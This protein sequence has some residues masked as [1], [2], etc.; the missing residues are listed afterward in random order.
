MEPSIY[1]KAIYNFVSDQSG[2][3][4]VSAGAGSGKTTTIVEC[5]N[6]IVAGPN[7]GLRVAFVAFNRNIAEELKRRLPPQVVACTLNSMGFKALC[8]VQRNWKLDGRKNVI[9]TRENMTSEAQKVYGEGVRKLIGLAKAHGILPAGMGGAALTLDTEQNW[10]DL[11]TKYDIEFEAGAEP[12]KGIEM[13]REALKV[14][15]HMA[16]ERKIVDFDDQLYLPIIWN[17]PFAQYD[18]IFADESQDI[19]AIQRAMLKKSLRPGGRLIAVGDRSQAIYGFRGADT[20]SMDNIKKE[21]AAQELPL[22]I[23]YRCAKA[24]CAEASRH[25]TIEAAESAEVGTVDDWKSA[26]AN[27]EG[28]ES[29]SAVL[30]RNNAPLVGLAFALMAQGKPVKMLGRDFGEGLIRMI[31]KTKAKSMDQ[32]ESG[33][34]KIESDQIPYLMAKGKEDAAGRLGDQIE[35]LRM[36]I[37]NLPKEDRSIEGL[38]RYITNLFNDDG[39]LITLSSVHKSKGLEWDHVYI[40][41]AHLMPSRYARQDWQKQQE[42]NIQYVALTRARKHLT[43][44]KSEEVR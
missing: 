24:I 42:T 15:I 37:S 14:S 27:G 1:Q 39:G 44:V 43:Y 36:F 35:S 17:A 32:L 30:C 10:A 7:A 40:L 19:N 29:G 38:K 23:S 11:M 31:D 25:G 18:V 16:E 8:S 20:E 3:L 13:A 9:I 33:L 21:F 12:L 28:F 5:A 22:T 41:D 34:D 4:V 26:N 6:R 2:S